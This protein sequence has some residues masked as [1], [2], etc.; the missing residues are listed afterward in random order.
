MLYL[1]LT[2]DKAGRTVTIKPLAHG[3]ALGFG[4]YF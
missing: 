4:L 1:K 3:P 2:D